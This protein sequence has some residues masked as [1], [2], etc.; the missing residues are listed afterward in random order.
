MGEF[1]HFQ[2]LL[3]DIISIS[4]ANG[5]SLVGVLELCPQ[6]IKS[7]DKNILDNI[8]DE[9]AT[10]N[11]IFDRLY[12]ITNKLEVMQYIQ[13]RNIKNTIILL[14]N[15]LAQNSE[16]ITDLENSCQCFS[17]L[18]DPH[19]N[20][21]HLPTKIP[22]IGIDEYSAQG[23]KVHNP[24]GVSISANMGLHQTD[25]PSCYGI[26]IRELKNMSFASKAERLCEFKDENFVKLLLNS[27]NVDMQ[28]AEAYFTSGSHLMPGYLQSCG[29]TT[30]FIGTYVFKYIS[31]EKELDGN[32][33]F[34]L[35]DRYLDPKMIDEVLSRMVKKNDI[36]TQPTLYYITPETKL[37]DIQPLKE[38]CIRI[39]SGFR[40]KR[41]DCRALYYLTEAGAGLSGDNSCT[42]VF[43]SKNI[44]FNL[45]TALRKDSSFTTKF[46]LK[47]ANFIP[48][49]YKKLKTYF[50]AICYSS[51]SGNYEEYKQEFEEFSR[52]EVFSKMALEHYETLLNKPY[53]ISTELGALLKDPELQK[54]WEKFR[55]FVAQEYNYSDNFKD[56]ILKGSLCI[57]AGIQPLAIEAKNSLMN[58]Q[59]IPLNVSSE[60]NPRTTISVNTQN[61][62][63]FH[64]TDTNNLPFEKHTL[65]SNYPPSN[66][67]KKS[68]DLDGFAMELKNYIENENCKGII[69]TFIVELI[70]KISYMK[71]ES[72]S[73]DPKKQLEI[74]PEVD[75]KLNSII[76]KYRNTYDKILKF[77]P[78]RPK[79]PDRSCSLM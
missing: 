69:A 78:S 73:Y 19:I 55:E 45:S 76:L 58:E 17:I 70:D 15:E 66:N 1:A 11:D 16:Y 30:C 3:T 32:C 60:N 21:P 72:S 18:V 6:T 61:P 35:N 65:F 54:E 47:F 27:N 44:P 24:I 25:D 50:D 42:D 51:N 13:E 53:E 52:S 43:S 49:E 39:F 9:L 74:P 2:E 64:I 57:A 40:L 23:W 26:K 34:Y 56:F 79:P 59:T 10:S 62:V 38:P 37:A 77:Q 28:H 31:Q 36:K 5:Y 7:S 8:L 41:E 12:I 20:P 63:V 22:I 33:D 4:R 71:G 46:W 75:D 29:S 48:A 67:P 14:K 68:I